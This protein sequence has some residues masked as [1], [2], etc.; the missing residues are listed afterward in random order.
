[1]SPT[2]KKEHLAIVATR[3]KKASRGERPGRCSVVQFPNSGPAYP[4]FSQG[5]TA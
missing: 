3:Y 5:P 4:I 1:M 2:A